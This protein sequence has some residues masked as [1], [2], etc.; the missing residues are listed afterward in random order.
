[1]DAKEEQNCSLTTGEVDY[2]L[3]I[4]ERRESEDLGEVEEELINFLKE[5]LY[6]IKSKQVS[7]DEEELKEA[8]RG[9]EESPQIQVRGE[10]ERSSMKGSLKKSLNQ[11]IALNLK[12][13]LSSLTIG[14]VL[15]KIEEDFL[16]IL[17]QNYKIYI[18]LE[19]IAAIQNG[20]KDF[21]SQQSKREDSS[22][23]KNEEQEIEEENKYQSSSTM[24]ETIDNNDL[25]A[26]G[27][28]I[29]QNLDKEKLNLKKSESTYL[30]EHKGN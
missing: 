26:E 20:V 3:E 13:S 9:E 4:L 29:D 28:F 8:P 18:K 25:L 23:I 5:Q 2:L 11:T 24:K 14:G 19:E 17:H 27:E 1:M 10:S 12:S 15:C 16:T 22:N 30:K 6:K 7:V 21:N